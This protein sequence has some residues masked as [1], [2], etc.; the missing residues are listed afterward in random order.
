MQDHDK[1]DEPVIELGQASTETRGQALFDID[2]G[3]GQLRYVAGIVE[4]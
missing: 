4:D 1:R 3:G 2:P